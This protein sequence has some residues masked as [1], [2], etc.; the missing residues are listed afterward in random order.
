MLK[1]I[2]QGFIY[3]GSLKKYIFGY[4]I[5]ERDLKILKFK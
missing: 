4:R 1:K 2:R 5:S 3:L